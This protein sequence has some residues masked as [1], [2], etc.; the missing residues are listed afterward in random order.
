MISNN[1]NKSSKE[2][3]V[4]EIVQKSKFR[5]N[6]DSI[7]LLEAKINEG[8]SKPASLVHTPISAFNKPSET[9][10]F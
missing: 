2:L 1:K 10:P 8:L 4:E 9:S 6:I 3:T 7:C 5:K